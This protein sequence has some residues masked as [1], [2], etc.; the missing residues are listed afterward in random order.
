[1]TF[2]QSC[3]GSSRCRTK[4]LQRF[5]RCWPTLTGIMRTAG[6]TSRALGDGGA[7][8][9]LNNG[10]GSFQST[11]KGWTISV[12]TGGW[13][14]TPVP[15][16]PRMSL[17]YGQLAV[18]IRFDERCHHGPEAGIFQKGT[19]M[20]HGIVADARNRTTTQCGDLAGFAD[21]SR[22]NIVRKAKSG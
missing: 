18:L 2:D 3:C 14:N 20:C 9:S 7:W 5:L 16:R 1:M 6:L 22:P 15:D 8:L 19:R 21:G 10:N 12:T 4:G 11:Q 17:I 13:R